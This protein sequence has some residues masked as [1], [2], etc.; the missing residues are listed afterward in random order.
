MVKGLNRLTAAFDQLLKVVKIALALPVSTASNERFFSV[1]KRVKTCL[2]TTCGQDR[3]SNL[4]LIAVE[5]DCADRCCLDH[6][7]DS[8]GRM[9]V[10]RYPV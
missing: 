8:F 1:L 5:N 9:K 7:V 2:R 6:L 4:L 10:R 3:L